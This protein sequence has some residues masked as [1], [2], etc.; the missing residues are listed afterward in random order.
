MAKPAN[1]KG[2]INNVRVLI[3]THSNLMLCTR[4]VCSGRHMQTKGSGLKPLCTAPDSSSDYTTNPYACAVGQ[5][6]VI[7]SFKCTP[8]RQ[9][10]KVAPTHQYQCSYKC[11]TVL[12]PH[13]HHN[14][15]PDQLLTQL[16]THWT[17]ELFFL[18]PN[19]LNYRQGLARVDSK[20]HSVCDKYYRLVIQHIIASL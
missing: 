20:M 16:I 17:A 14:T 2:E 18:V 19:E 9:P 3:K 8:F 12:L 13:H 10:G 11:S 6:M 7:Y 5:P 15:P 4:S 1:N